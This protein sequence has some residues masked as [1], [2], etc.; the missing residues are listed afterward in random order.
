MEDQNSFNKIAN[1][2]CTAIALA[3]AVATI[4]LNLLGPIAFQT[5]ALFLGIAIFCLAIAT[6]N[7]E[8]H[9]D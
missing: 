6:L 2:A 7:R 8:E 3:M 4:V 9:H 1:L 5:T